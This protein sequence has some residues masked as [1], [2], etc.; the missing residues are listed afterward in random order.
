MY[1]LTTECSASSEDHMSRSMQVA[2][3]SLAGVAAMMLSG[4]SSDVGSTTTTKTSTTS[5]P[6]SQN[7]SG[8]EDDWFASVCKQNPPINQGANNYYGYI[9]SFV[10]NATAQPGNLTFEVFTDYDTMM[11]YIE[12]RFYGCNALGS[13][14]YAYYVRTTG[15]GC[16]SLQP[17][18]KFGFDIV[19]K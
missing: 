2:L 17:L 15:D 18:S 12:T 3:T 1:C 14:D 10:C 19:T 6:S 11:S 16:G 8:T 9:D 13:A 5:A 7:L 4:C